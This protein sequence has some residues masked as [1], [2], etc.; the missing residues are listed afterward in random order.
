[1][2]KSVSI[3]AWWEDVDK[4]SA[5]TIPT[6]SVPQVASTN[7]APKVV[8]T[9]AVATAVSSDVKPQEPKVDA[10][11]RKEAEDRVRNAETAAAEKLAPGKFGS[12]PTAYRYLLEGPITTV[13]DA[14]LPDDALVNKRI[15]MLRD[16]VAE[17]GSGKLKDNDER[18]ALAKRLATVKAVGDTNEHYEFPGI[19]SLD[20]GP[21]G[22]SGRSVTSEGPK[23]KTVVPEQAPAAPGSEPV[24]P[25]SIHYESPF[26]E[27]DP[28]EEPSAQGQKKAARGTASAERESVPVKV[29]DD[30]AFYRYG[31]NVARARLNNDYSFG[32]LSWSDRAHLERNGQ[33]A[34]VLAAR[35]LPGGPDATDR[36]ARSDAELY[37]RRERQV[38]G[39]RTPEWLRERI[40]RG[41]AADIYRMHGSGSRRG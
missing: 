23:P 14:L 8:S 34:S 27:G 26:Y 39:Y 18:L 32:Q 19:G 24:K 5:Y 13:E 36:Q 10:P 25:M 29:Y 15:K 16:L 28:E 12:N 30:S 2:A 31:G 6:N 20:I 40:A 41:G 9:N 17:A 37:G 33:L 35:S 1:M 11:G 3:G 22:E 7:D 4:T 38:P 21:G